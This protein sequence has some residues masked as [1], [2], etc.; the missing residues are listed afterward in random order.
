MWISV[1][2]MS[3]FIQIPLKSL[4][5]ADPDTATW[6]CVPSEGVVPLLQVGELLVAVLSTKTAN[7]EL[8]G[9][10]VCKHATG[11]EQIATIPSESILRCVDSASGAPSLRARI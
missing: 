10:E 6:P 8:T 4:L 5:K 1:K 9:S 2:Y 7:L 11:C 3:K